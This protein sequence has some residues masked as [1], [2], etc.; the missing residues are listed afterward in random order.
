MND[1]SE[2]I[3]AREK[4]SRQIKFTNTLLSVIVIIFIVTSVLL[5]SSLK[6]EKA[7]LI[8][9]ETNLQTSYDSITKIKDK[10][11]ISDSILSLQNEKLLQLRGSIDKIWEDAQNANTIKD[12]A[13]YLERA[14]DGD[15][16]YNTALTRIDQLAKKNGYVEI[17]DSDGTKYFQK[18]ES[19]SA[20]GEFYKA[21][22]DRSVRYGVKGDSR[23][24][25]QDRN[26]DAIVTGNVVKVIKTFSFNSGTE[27]AEIRY[28]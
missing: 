3:K 14:I 16:N 24:S 8:K 10:L 12:Y 27:W 11:T 25:N 4:K 13:S 17:T 9:S 23:F 20:E 18:I 28:Q 7:A 19:L 21:L 15:E 5:Y 26:G 1:L 6:K 2:R 22:A